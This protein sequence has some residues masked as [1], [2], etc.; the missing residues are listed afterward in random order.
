MTRRLFPLS[1][2]L[3]GSLFLLIAGGINGL[4]LPIRGLSEGFSAFSLGLLGTGWAAGYVLGCIYTPVLVAGAGH[5]RVFSVFA[6]MAA[7]VILLSAMFPS[8]WVWIPLRAVSG[9]CF[10][11][12]AMIVES[13][14][15]EVD[16]SIRGQVFGT[17]T[18]INLAGST[19]GQMLLI[20]ADVSTAWY[21]MLGAIF[22][23]LAL[24]PTAIST[25]RA[26]APLF[27]VK[28]KILQ[29]WQN[30]PV[31]VFAVLM[32]GISNGGFA[33]LAPVYAQ[34]IGLDL[35][36]VVLF[37]SLPILAGAA[38]QIPVGRASDRFDR[39]KVLV[40]TALIAMAAGSGF[41][42]MQPETANANLLLGAA[43]GAMIYAMYPIVVAHA[44]DHAGPGD[45]IT[46]SG[47]LLLV[48]GIGSIIGPFIGGLA[49]TLSGPLALFVTMIGAHLLI[50][51]FS[52]WRI[53]R[54]EEPDFGDKGSFQ[55]IPQARNSTPETGVLAGR[56]GRN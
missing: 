35:T 17:Y 2:L 19:G 30:S 1:A 37:S 25:R 45:Y 55:N 18:M 26:P 51:L 6:A 27:E 48:F 5:I 46:T 16:S 42:F 14:L 4:I 29:L 7:I 20:G 53:M 13:W 3:L 38:A 28:L 11:G 52:I 39:R 41:L 24:I 12:A 44:N 33:A 8:P 23:C 50:L 31:A 34:R 47:G 49:I 36:T 10:A 32:I 40:L 43:L 9:F 21:F 56:Q 22:Y 15:K 54:R